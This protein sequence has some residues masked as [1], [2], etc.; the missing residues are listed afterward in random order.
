MSSSPT[1]SHLFLRGVED[2]PQPSPY[3]DAIASAQDAG[4]EYWGIWNLLA[5]RPKTGAT[6]KPPLSRKIRKPCF[7]S[8]AS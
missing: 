1:G 3:A 8:R 5:F 2:N 6:S 7:A 4:V